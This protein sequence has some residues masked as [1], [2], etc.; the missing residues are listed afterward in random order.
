[1]TDTTKIL[2]V[3]AMEKEIRDLLKELEC[4]EDSKLLGQYPF[5][6]GNWIK[7]KKHVSIGVVNTFVGDLNASV[8]TLTAIQKFNPHYVFKVGCVGG[9]SAGI[10]KGEI[11]LPCGYFH[12][13]SWI[14]R[15]NTDNSPTSNAFLWQ[16]VFGD[17]PYQVNMDNLGNIPYFFVPDKKLSKKY[18][19]LLK[20]KQLKYSSAYIGGGNMW[21]FDKRYMSNVAAT[22]IPKN[23]PHNRWVA[24][25]ESFAIAHSCFILKKPFFGFY[26]VSNS[27][28]YHEPYIPEDIAEMF[29]TIIVP[30]ISDYL[31][32]L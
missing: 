5:F 20:I 32:L 27:D 11:I 2:F 31:S 17:L 3:G 6:T 29:G 25:M 12:S 13:A 1:M 9:N 18:E 15:S 22:Q 7:D 4:V 28:Y 8:A 14:T 23:S 10:H 24:D 19:E 16:S 21:F 26:V 30:T